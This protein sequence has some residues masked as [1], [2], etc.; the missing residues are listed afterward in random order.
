MGSIKDIDSIPSFVENWQTVVARV[1]DNFIVLSD[2]R[3]MGIQGRKIEKLHEK[4]QSFL[5]KKE[6]SEV[7]EV[8]AMNDIADLQFSQIVKRSGITNTRFKDIKTAEQYLDTVVATLKKLK[9]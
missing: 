3:A 4:V 8:V 1:Q 2:V 7:A 6:V 9:S 5:T